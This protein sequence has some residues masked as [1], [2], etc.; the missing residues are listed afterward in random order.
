METIKISGDTPFFWQWDIDRRVELSGAENGYVIHF[1]QE[2]G[3]QGLTGA[4]GYENLLRLGR[5]A[6]AGFVVRDGVAQVHAALVG[7]VM[8]HV[9]LQGGDGGGTDGL[10]G[11][12]VRFA[13][14]EH[15]TA[16]SLPGQVGK[17]ADHTPLQA[18]KIAV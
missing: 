4:D 2:G 11:I 14:G 7:G 18:G 13:D 10:R 6:P 16:R 9:L 1:V 17:L 8:G 3:E 5:V 15:G 12:E